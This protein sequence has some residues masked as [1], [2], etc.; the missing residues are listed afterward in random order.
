MGSHLITARQSSSHFSAS[1]KDLLSNLMEE[2]SNALEEK[3]TD[4]M[5]VKKKEDSLGVLCDRFNGSSAIKEKRDTDEDGLEKLKS[6]KGYVRGEE[7]LLQ[8]RGWPP[9]KGIGNR[10]QKICKMIPQQFALLRKPY[11]DDGQLNST[12]FSKHK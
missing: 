12:I 9:S 3:T 6:Q 11:D 5:T 7:G 4:N 8:T 2:F 10:S 1:E